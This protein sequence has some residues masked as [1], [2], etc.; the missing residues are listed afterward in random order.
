MNS[1]PSYEPAS[2]V[3]TLAFTMHRGKLNRQQ[4]DCLLVNGVIHQ[5]SVLPIT[6]LRLATNDVLFAVAD[7][8]A[9]SP[10]PRRASRT[11]L[12]ALA[13]VVQERAEWR[14]EGFVSA[15]HL[16]QAQAHLA[17]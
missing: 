9:S 8:V 7:G 11:V 1:E 17:K 10:A 2:E 6:S 13:R 3:L 14:Y 5:E 15:R 4:Q 12:E 16:R